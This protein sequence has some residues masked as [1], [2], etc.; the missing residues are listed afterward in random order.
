MTVPPVPPTPTVATGDAMAAHWN[1]TVRLEGVYR[2]RQMPMGYRMMAQN[3]DGTFRPVRRLARLELGDGV[4]V[5][6]CNPRPDEEL[7]SHDGLAVYAIGRLEPPEPPRSPHAAAAQ[8]I[9]TLYDIE[10]IGTLQA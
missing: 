7:D 6:L 9:P 3:P 5:S 1:Q 2:V 4:L 8:T 10:G